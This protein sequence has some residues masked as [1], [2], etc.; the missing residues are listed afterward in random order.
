MAE[1]T[2]RRKRG[3]GRAGAAA[4]RGSAVIEQ[5]PWR[6]PQNLDAPTEPLNEEGIAVASMTKGI[7]NCR[8]RRR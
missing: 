7:A 4:R 3:G 5:M 6:I 2:T 1:T 8:F